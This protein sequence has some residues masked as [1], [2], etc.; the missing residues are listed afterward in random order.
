MGPE[1]KALDFR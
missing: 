1:T